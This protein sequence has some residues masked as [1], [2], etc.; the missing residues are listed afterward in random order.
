MRRG[1]IYY[2]DLDPARTGEANKQRPV[3]IVSNNS[4]NITV[5]NLGEGVVTVVP[6]TSNTERVY[7]FQ[8]FLPA[9]ATGL[10]KDSK[11]QAEQVRSISLERL[12][13]SPM[14]QLPI[15]LLRQLEAALRLHLEL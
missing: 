6:I 10:P 3:I 12:S 2:A 11:A 9:I 5:K 1:E 8:V 7:E 14:G 13:Q 15:N 4:M